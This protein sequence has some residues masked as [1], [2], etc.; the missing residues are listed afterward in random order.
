MIFSIKF[1]N[2]TLQNML[3]KINITFL[4]CGTRKKKKK[5]L[6]RLAAATMATN[7]I[8]FLSSLKFLPNFFSTVTKPWKLLLSSHYLS[9]QSYLH[10]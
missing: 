6:A 1:A 9:C 10:S 5:R 8:S 4:N 2:S 7:T 3:K